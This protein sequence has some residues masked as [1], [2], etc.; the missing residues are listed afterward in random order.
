MSVFLFPTY[1]IDSDRVFKQLYGPDI[2]RPNHHYAT[3]I[4]PCVY[5]FGPLHAFWTFLFERI[6]KVLKSYN[7]ANHAHGQLETSFFR[8]FHRTVQQ[9]RVVSLF[10]LCL[11]LLT[12]SPFRWLAH[13][14]TVMP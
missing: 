12:V 10:P 9:S 4:A 14:E 1:V 6:N 7:S 2:I 5:D 8:E 11:S 13:S 3:H